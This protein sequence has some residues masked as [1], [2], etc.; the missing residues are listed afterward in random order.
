MGTR[1]ES[2]LIDR[3][4]A[5]CQRV[6]PNDHCAYELCTIEAYFINSLFM[7]MMKGNRIDLTA[8][9]KLGFNPDEKCARKISQIPDTLYGDGSGDEDDY[10]QPEIQFSKAPKGSRV[11][12]PKPVSDQCCGTYPVRTPFNPGQQDKKSCC[13]NTVY[14]T[15]T[16]ECCEGT[17]VLPFGSC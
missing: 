17:D 15:F 7:F 11:D 1:D 2:Q 8:S 12:P 10:D 14:N 9:H 16:H 5:H 6:N 3:L 4:T 13:K